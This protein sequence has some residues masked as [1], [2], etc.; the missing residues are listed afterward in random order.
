MST[1]N[2]EES[3]LLYLKCG[4]PGYIA[5]EVLKNEGYCNKIDLYSAGVIFYTL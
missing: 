4:T 3:K 1:G 5:P 2:C